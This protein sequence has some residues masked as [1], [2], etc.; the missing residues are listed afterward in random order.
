MPRRPLPAPRPY[1]FNEPD[2][3]AFRTRFWRCPVRLVKDGTWARLWTGN[4]RRGRGGG[5]A[6]ALLPVLAVHG[7]REQKGSVPGWSG[8]VALSY[9]RLARLA[10]L[11]KDTVTTA[12]GHLVEAGLIR[13]QREPIGHD[14]PRVVARFRV[15]AR[16]YPADGER[17]VS[18]AAAF[19]YGGGWSRLPGAAARHLAVA[20]SAW[21]E[22]AI[23]NPAIGN[24]PR[25]PPLLAKAL[26]APSG[27]GRTAL[28]RA[29][30]ELLAW[31][32]PDGAFLV[33]HRET[34]SRPKLDGVAARYEWPLVED[35]EPED[36]VADFTP[37]SEDTAPGEGSREPGWRSS[38]RAVEGSGPA[39]E[40]SQVEAVEDAAGAPAVP[41]QASTQCDCDGA[42]GTT[43]PRAGRAHPEGGEPAADDGSA[44]GRAFEHTAQPVKP[45][46]VPR[47][48]LQPYAAGGFER[49]KVWWVE[50]YVSAWANRMLRRS[51]PPDRLLYVD[52][53]PGNWSAYASCALRRVAEIAR[54]MHRRYHMVPPFEVLAI[55]RDA[56]R[57]GAL[58]GNVPIEFF[59]VLSVAGGPVEEVLAKRL[60]RPGTAVLAF[61]G[62]VR[63]AGLASTAIRLILTGPDRELVA[64][65]GPTAPDALKACLCSRGNSG[66]P[67]EV[68]RFARAAMGAGARQV[69]LEP[70]A[71]SAGEA[72][73]A[74]LHAAT[75]FGA[76]GAFKVATGS[77]SAAAEDRV[78]RF[79]VEGGSDV[80][81]VAEQL[82][83]RFAG[84]EIRWSGEAGAPAVRRHLLEHTA[85]STS[86]FAAIRRELSQ[87]GW[88]LSGRGN[89]YRF[90]KV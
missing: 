82:A 5:A 70:V 67:T 90:P 55:E 54:G 7:W 49:M 59:S 16:V 58:G 39:R 46:P 53:C 9:R 66:A 45:R 38:G 28:T 29:V 35:P 37:A 2:R 31:G 3:A 36:S 34:L 57:A 26:M 75:M 25:T 11:D 80:V 89:V 20:W 81:E 24:Y 88:R 48:V 42:V 33:E 85:V 69:L 72:V 63:T 50:R 6:G 14:D 78:E 4:G 71:T 61:A 64:A 43:T 12:V 51:S 13:V 10:G 68:E 18:F 47:R 86:E 40:C 52:L 30:T 87:R 73:G 83:R 77:R 17:Y 15:A 8:S 22:Q 76:L 60:N 79:C 56:E 1:D 21:A 62:D 32:S 44:R 65:C 41:G 27:M 23:V 19:V 84:R 74:L